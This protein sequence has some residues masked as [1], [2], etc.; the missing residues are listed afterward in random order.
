VSAPLGT[1]RLDTASAECYSELR[2]ERAMNSRPTRKR[3]VRCRPLPARLW[4]ETVELASGAL[5][6]QGT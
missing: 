4:L 1:G 5:H 2:V 3:G 6:G